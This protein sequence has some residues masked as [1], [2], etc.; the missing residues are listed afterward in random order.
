[1]NALASLL[2]FLLSFGISA[3]QQLLA[4]PRCNHWPDRGTCEDRGFQIKWYYDRYD[5]RCR[6]FFYGGCDGNENRFDTLEE[7][8]SLCRFSEPTDRDR[9]FQPHD[10]GYCNADIERWFF[11]FR[12][13]QCVCSWWSGCGGNSNI[14]YSYNHC[15]LICG[16][17]A[18]HGPGIDE[19]Y[20]GKRN[21]TL[22][23]AESSRVLAHPQAANHVE[24]G[25]YSVQVPSRD[26]SPKYAAA[27]APAV[28]YIN[29]SHIDD[30][31]L[32]DQPLR[33]VFSQLRFEPPPPPKLKIHETKT[34]PAQ[35]LQSH[36]VNRITLFPKNYVVRQAYVPA[37]PSNFQYRPMQKIEWKA[38]HQNQQPLVQAVP[39]YQMQSHPENPRTD[40]VDRFRAQ[41]EN[42]KETL[43]RQLEARF[44]GYVITLIPQTETHETPD[45]RQTVRQRIQ[46][47]AHPKTGQTTGWQPV[48]TNIQNSVPPRPQNTFETSAAPVKQKKIH[49]TYVPARQQ[50]YYQTQP[51]QPVQPVQ[52]AQQAVQYVPRQPV[53]TPQPERPVYTTTQPP[54]RPREVIV[55]P[56]QV[57][58]TEPYRTVP[59][60]TTTRAPYVP[61]QRTLP[62]AQ[63]TPVDQHRTAVERVTPMPLSLD[64]IIA[65][66]ERNGDVQDDFV[67]Y[68]TSDQPEPVN[69]RPPPKATAPPARVA[70]PA[71]PAPAADKTQYS[72]IVF[73]VSTRPP[74]RSPS[75]RDPQD[76]EYVQEL[77]FGK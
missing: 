61:P 18:E 30:A 42:H 64:D 16:S 47:T 21:G 5:H 54:Y 38:A 41:L 2:L 20:W 75:R 12:K 24:Q 40:I 43:R 51:V 13:K 32:V 65:I 58:P 63:A 72:M 33:R 74:A 53:A 19:N 11:D 44:P 26:I 3:A 4:E 71:P 35:E 7:C 56:T 1:M 6:R 14:F 23:S 8:S 48:S 67:D 76:D 49:K 68:E 27:T 52:P 25:F 69:T 57:I 55:P 77:E 37:H 29:I 45:G 50:Q 62:P 36:Y 22:M 31:P 10:P 66:D 15:M 39:Q 59:T 28:S 9:C 34:L 46:W 70:P 17:F 73:P 60:T